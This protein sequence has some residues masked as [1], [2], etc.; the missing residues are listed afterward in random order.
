MVVIDSIIGLIPIMIVH[1]R[2]RE[3]SKG[4]DLIAWGIVVLFFSAIFNGTK[5]SINEYFT[6][7]DMAHVFIIINLWV[8]FAGIKRKAIS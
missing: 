8:M 1:F 5:I 2:D 4:S 7:L 6:Y 3:K